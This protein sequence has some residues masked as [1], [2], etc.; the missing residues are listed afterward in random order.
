MPSS[1]AWW[2]SSGGITVMTLALRVVGGGIGR[3]Q[4]PAGQPPVGADQPEVRHGVCDL[5][6]PARLEVRQQVELAGVVG[7]VMEK[8]HWDAAVRVVAAAQRARRQVRGCQAS[9]L[10]ADHARGADDLGALRL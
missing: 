7:P 1:G 6:A 10:P 2:S 3:G 4:W 9:R 5:G 8:A